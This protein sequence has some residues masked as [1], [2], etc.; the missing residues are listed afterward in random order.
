MGIELQ[1]SEITLIFYV[2]PPEL[3]KIFL[4]FLLTKCSSGA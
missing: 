4:G 2:A 3:F 1:R